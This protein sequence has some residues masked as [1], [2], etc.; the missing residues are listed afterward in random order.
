[1]GTRIFI[2]LSFY[3]FLTLFMLIGPSEMPRVFFKL[4][5]PS[6]K[7]KFLQTMKKQVFLF[8]LFMTFWRCPG[9]VSIL[10]SLF[11]DLAPRASTLGL[12][13]TV[14]CPLNFRKLSHVLF[15]FT[16]FICAL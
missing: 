7:F 11:R 1:M 14:L 4:D 5:G 9:V 12:D 2:I 10:R 8:W 13:D 3:P 6:A 15:V 16:P